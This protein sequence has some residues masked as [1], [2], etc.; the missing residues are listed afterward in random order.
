MV[1]DTRRVDPSPV[2]I[3]GRSRYEMRGQ[4]SRSERWVE[5]PSQDR[6]TSTLTDLDVADCCRGCVRILDR[7]VE[8]ITQV[9]DDLHAPKVSR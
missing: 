6:I 9:R 5:R 4:C 7:M 3:H 2:E 8:H 1:G